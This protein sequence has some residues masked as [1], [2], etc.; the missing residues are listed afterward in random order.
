MKPSSVVLLLCMGF[1]PAVES[2]AD[3]AEPSLESI[4]APH[5]MQPSDLAT[6]L[7]S[8][9]EKPLVLQVGSRMLFAQ[10]HVPGSEYI[11]AA[12]Q[13]A[14][15]QALEARVQKLDRSQ[16]MVIYC[17]CCPWPK[18]P[19]IHRAY[20]KLVGMGFTHVRVL[21]I[22]ENFGADW[23]DKGFPITKGEQ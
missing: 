8:N 20:D 10:A 11:G 23:V 3:A 12:G 6:A 1:M 13:D 19:N 4:P 16:P 9:D 7:Q 22:A 17:G 15:L 2:A 21:Y 5:L 14:G 18:C